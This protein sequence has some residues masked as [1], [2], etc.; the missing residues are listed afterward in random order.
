MN[1]SGSTVRWAEK[2]FEFGRLGHSEIWIESV[3]RPTEDRNIHDVLVVYWS[4]KP[5][6]QNSYPSGWNV[7]RGT[8]PAM[9]PASPDVT[10]LNS[11]PITTPMWI[12]ETAET[13]VSDQIY[14]VVTELRG[15]GSETPIDRPVTL[16]Q[17]FGGEDREMLSPIRIYREMRRRKGLLLGRTAEI[18]DLLIRK[19]AGSRCG[20]CFLAQYESVLK[21]DCGTCFGTGWERG[22]EL[23]R[24]VRCRVSTIQETLK[25]QPAGF[26]FD[27]R[28]RGW[29]VDFPILRNGDV[30]VRR[31]GERYE[32][33]QTEPVIH[34]GV[35]TEQ[36]FALTA[37]PQLHPI[38]SYV[39]TSSD[40]VPA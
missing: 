20:A 27:S 40:A 15:D 8:N 29:L 7:Y 10:K 13:R 17:W 28:P 18:T 26:V 9:T 24:S 23:L 1:Q 33:D 32:V 38:F 14:Y 35:L 39:I 21:S 30:V 22:Y 16:N 4:P 6:V 37:L 31:N 5:F 25:L 3:S 36:N 2:P 11:A 34:Q 12:D 19:R